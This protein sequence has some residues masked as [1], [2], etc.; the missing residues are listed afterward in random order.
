M[1][2]AAA[3]ATGFDDTG[4]PRPPRLIQILSRHGAAADHPVAGFCPETEY[5]KSVWMRV[6]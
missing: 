4:R 3:K 6:I 2:R 5:L 1:I